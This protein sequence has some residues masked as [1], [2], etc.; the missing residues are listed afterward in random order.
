MT[1]LIS[2]PDEFP[3]ATTPRP[4]EYVARRRLPYD[5]T[6][7]HIAAEVEAVTLKRR[8]EFERGKRLLPADILIEI[9]RN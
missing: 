3:D 2:T 8:E 6:Y 1:T 7:Q 9:F 4:R 5:A